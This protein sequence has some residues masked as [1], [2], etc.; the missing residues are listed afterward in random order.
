LKITTLGSPE[1]NGRKITSVSKFSS[2]SVLISLD[3]DYKQLDDAFITIKRGGV[4]QLLAGDIKITNGENYPVNKVFTPFY[5]EGFNNAQALDTW[6]TEFRNGD[7][8][9]EDGYVKKINNNDPNGGYVHLGQTITSGKIVSSFR[10]NRINL[11]GGSQD[12]VSIGELNSSQADGYGIG[13]TPGQFKIEERDSS[14]ATTL[15]DDSSFSRDDG[16]WYRVIFTIDIDTDMISAI[17]FN[18]AGDLVS[19]LSVED[20][21]YNTFN[22]FFIHGG[23]EFAVDDIVIGVIE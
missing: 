15:V 16:D 1:E 2:N 9:Y 14:N 13:L 4:R 6:E 10:I 22:H 11:N 21:T 3:K 17:L 7:L 23:H 8:V 20:D 18:E 12:R 19:S 5:T